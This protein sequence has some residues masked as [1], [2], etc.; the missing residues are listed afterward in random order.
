[1][2]ESLNAFSQLFSTTIT[3]LMWEIFGEGEFSET[4]WR[5][6]ESSPS[7]ASVVIEND[8][9]SDGVG[10]KSLCTNPIQALCKKS[11]LVHF[12]LVGF[13]L[14]KT[15]CIEKCDMQ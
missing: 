10:I 12:S 6:I 14:S 2:K 5:A 13:V 3:C 9:M 7:L 8:V 11:G 15:P 1:M 4:V